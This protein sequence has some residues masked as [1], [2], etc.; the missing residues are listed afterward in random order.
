MRAAA[1][2]DEQR[3]DWLQ[4]IR[5]ENIG[6]RSFHKLMLRH[7]SAAAALAAL[8]ALIR[9]GVGRKIAIASRDSCARELAAAHKLG[10]RYIALGELDYPQGLVA[11]RRAAAA[12]L[13]A[14]RPR[15][16]RAANCRGGRAPGT[17]PAPGSPSPSA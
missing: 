17:P 2:T 12:D 5:C 16:F 13:P 8:P 9:Q 14:R 15:F 4:L 3:L 1:L 7:G 11:H 10:A 6:P